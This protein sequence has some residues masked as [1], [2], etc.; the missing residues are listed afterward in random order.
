[1]EELGLGICRNA[2]HFSAHRANLFTP[3]AQEEAG[4]E[5]DH[6]DSGGGS[7][8]GICLGEVELSRPGA[9]VREEQ[10]HR[11]EL[12][13]IGDKL[14]QSLGR[15]GGVEVDE[16]L[17][18]L[19]GEGGHNLEQLACG[20][21]ELRTME[22]RVLQEGH[23]VVEGLSL[24]EYLIL[25]Q[26]GGIQVHRV[27]KGVGNA[28]HVK[29]EQSVERSPSCPDIDRYPRLLAQSSLP[30]LLGKKKALV[31]CLR[32]AEGEPDHAG[33]FLAVGEPTLLGSVNHFHDAGLC[34]RRCHCK[35]RIHALKC[36][37]IGK[38]MHNNM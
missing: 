19:D 7:D 22:L 14:S 2:A 30:L 1:M 32:V 8:E 29:A 24:T 15:V 37:L 23:Y 11:Y 26:L 33:Y 35:G 28:G 9:V 36:W 38:V 25:L 20:S 13:K 6:H 27:N 31:D 34:D 17:L 10:T 3:F 16:C 21:H 4:K 12:V 5:E 18:L